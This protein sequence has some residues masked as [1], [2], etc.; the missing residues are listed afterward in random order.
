MV[1]HKG[2]T[3]NTNQAECLNSRCTAHSSNYCW[4]ENLEAVWTRL[5]QSWSSMKRFPGASGKAREIS[6]TGKGAMVGAG[7]IV[8]EALRCNGDVDNSGSP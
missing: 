7:M 8:V 1:Y 3:C 4:L 5:S 6:R 2:A